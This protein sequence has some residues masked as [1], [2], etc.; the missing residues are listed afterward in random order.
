MYKLGQQLIQP[1]TFT[2]FRSWLP[3]LQRREFVFPDRQQSI[4]AEEIKK[5]ERGRRC[6]FTLCCVSSNAEGRV[7]RHNTCWTSSDGST[8]CESGFSSSHRTGWSHPFGAELSSH[9]WSAINQKLK[10]SGAQGLLISASQPPPGQKPHCFSFQSHQAF[11]TSPTEH[12]RVVFEKLTKAF[13]PSSTFSLKKCRDHNPSSQT[14]T[15]AGRRRWAS[16]RGFYCSSLKLLPSKERNMVDRPQGRSL[17]PHYSHK[18]NRDLSKYEFGC[19]RGSLG[20]CCEHNV[21]SMGRSSS[22]ANKGR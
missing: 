9:C 1:L 11:S 16:R 10:R 7:G 12:L 21:T 18:H 13:P 20:F 6:C 17:E 19:S 14:R 22:A 2:H 8:W 5:G 4:G 15:N 3:G